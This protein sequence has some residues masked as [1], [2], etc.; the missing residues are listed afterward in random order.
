MR[1]FLWVASEK[2]TSHPG[3]WVGGLGIARR[4]IINKTQ[5]GLRNS[6]F[7]NH[8]HVKTRSVTKTN[9]VT[10]PTTRSF[11]LLRVENFFYGRQELANNVL[12]LTNKAIF[13]YCIDVLLVLSKRE[14][15]NVRIK[16]LS[17]LR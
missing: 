8:G 5:N 11:S 3:R 7:R 6:L 9:A 15:N 1:K 14:E 10:A 2:Y 4:L 17:P 13:T 12:A 16:T